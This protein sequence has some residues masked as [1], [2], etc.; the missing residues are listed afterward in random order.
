MGYDVSDFEAVDPAYGSLA[1]FDS[2]VARA[3]ERGI[4]VVMDYVACHTSIE[5]VWF[6]ERPERYIWSDR[7]GA[8]NNWIATFGGSAWSADPAGRGW[9][10]HSYYPEQPD[11]DWRNPDVVRAMRGVMR[12]WLDRGV[13]GFRLDAIDRL[14][15]DRDLRDDPPASAP[16]ALPLPEEYAKLE[17]LYSVNSPDIRAALA[18]L[19]GEAGDSLLVGEVYLPTAQLAPYLESLDL[20]FGFELFHS[21]W[22]Q[23]SL[24]AAIAAGVGLERGGRTATAWALSNHDFP[25]L[26]TR[27][28]SESLRAAAVLLLT[29]PGAA[30]VYQGDEIGLA[31]GPGADP[32]YDR[33]GRDG[34]RH[35][36]QWDASARGGFTTGEAWLPAVDPAERNVAAQLADP[37]SLL[38]LYRRLIAVR[39]D[40]SGPFE[41]LDAGE[42]VLAFRRGRHVVAVNLTAEPRSAPPF[43]ELV[44]ATH[45]AGTRLAPHAAL[46]ALD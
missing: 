9:Y 6:R 39:R 5:H 30:F 38:S 37:G 46:V 17:H 23:G 31:D 12:F 27:L 20:A 42:G 1:D 26:A 10:L 22:E 45:D 21:P 40:L 34:A 3:A 32:P 43:G 19:R 13:A 14:V 29:L 33:A 36:M 4:R 8:R 11:L 35:P 44:L 28:G 41:L 18:E 7:D 2:L 24:E 15:K 25:R 16:F